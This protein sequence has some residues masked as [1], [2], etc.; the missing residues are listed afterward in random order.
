MNQQPH[1][2]GSNMQVP[3]AELF[4]HYL[5]RQVSAHSNGW[6]G[7]ESLG[8]V[9]PYEVA[10]SQPV[11]PRLAWEEALVAVQCLAPEEKLTELAQPRDWA[12]L[13]A[14]HEPV[15]AL[16]LCTGNYPQL[17]RNFHGLLQAE[18]LT[19]LLPTVGRPVVSA[20]L[21]DWAST[22]LEKGVFPQS[23]IALGAL[24]LGKQFDAARKL[25]TEHGKHVPAAW[26]VAWSNEEAALA[27]H[28]G[29]GGCCRHHLEIPAGEP[30]GFLQ[31][32]PRGPL[33]RQGQRGST[34]VQPRGG[35]TAR[36]ERLASPR[37]SLSHSCGNARLRR[38]S[39]LRRSAR[40][41]PCE[42][43]AASG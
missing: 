1:D 8:E 29:R 26:S 35:A 4:R 31:L 11:D 27:W 42:R 30:A 5:E 34:C 15:V 6:A 39:R 43:Y 22:T 38:F 32:R 23:L 14:N 19:S 24:R 21:L 7:A 13:V 10:A 20:A 41:A 9:E 40:M 36:I 25:I 17:M 33:H 2:T 37:T 12:T 28:Q 18:D 3:L 16:P